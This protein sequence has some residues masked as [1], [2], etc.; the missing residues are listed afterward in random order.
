M[1]AV[2][3]YAK[4]TIDIYRHLSIAFRPTAVTR[5]KVIMAPALVSN[6]ALGISSLISAAASAFTCDAIM[7]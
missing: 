5:G 6:A 1:S 2:C 4:Y 3:G 7:S